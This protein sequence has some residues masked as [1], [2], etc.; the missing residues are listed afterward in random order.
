[1]TFSMN[2]ASAR[3]IRSMV[4]PG[5]GSGRNPT[6]PRHDEG[7]RVSARRHPLG[8]NDRNG[9]WCLEIRDQRRRYCRLFGIRRECR[10][11]HDVLLQLGGEWTDHVETGRVV[12]V[13]KEYAKFSLSL[14]P[15]RG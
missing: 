1:M 13:D 5:I 9:F 14:G 2:S 6:N 7:F 15:H 3:A 11:E 8:L 10:R 4:C 12:H